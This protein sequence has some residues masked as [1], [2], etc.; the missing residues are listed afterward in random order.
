LLSLFVNLEMTFFCKSK[1][2]QV[3][4]VSRVCVVAKTEQSERRSTV[5]NGEHDRSHG[6]HADDEAGTNDEDFGATE[7]KSIGDL[8]LVT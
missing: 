4:E 7:H 3:C 6:E 1:A 8:A 2:G 5:Q